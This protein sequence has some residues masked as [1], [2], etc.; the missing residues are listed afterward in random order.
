MDGHLGVAADL[1]ELSDRVEERLARPANM[2]GKHT[3]SA[4]EAPSQHGELFGRRVHPGRIDETRGET[5]GAV[6]KSRIEC[7]GHLPTGGFIRLTGG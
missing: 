6:I 2:R 4:G 3:A 7:I 5:E 1:D